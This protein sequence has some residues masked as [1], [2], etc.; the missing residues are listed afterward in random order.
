MVLAGATDTD[1]SAENLERLRAMPPGVRQTLLRRLTSFDALPSDEQQAIRELD[2]GVR[3]ADPVLRARY[4]AILDH[5]VTWSRNL[6]PADKKK[7]DEAAPADRITVVRS[8][9]DA[10]P[11]AAEPD[12]VETVAALSPTLNPI[13]LVD[14]AHYVTVWMSL[15]PEQKAAID[16]ASPAERA[17]RLEKLG[18]ELNIADARPARLRRVQQ[19]LEKRLASRAAAAKKMETPRALPKNDLARRVAEIKL[20]SQRREL[21]PVEPKQLE[22]FAAALPG[23]FRQTF[24]SLPPDAAR[25]RMGLLYRLIYPDSEMAEPEAAAPKTSTPALKKAAEPPPTGASG[26]P[27]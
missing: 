2:R 24:D 14:Q 6:R 15:T 8:L 3:E 13:S 10:A 5:F 16:S 17:V 1:R 22:R 27:F 18:N 11:R 23:W 7:L 12:R 21:R 20:L 9:L 26:S 25:L 19:D 4:Q